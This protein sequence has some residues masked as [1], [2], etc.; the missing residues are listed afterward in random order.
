MREQSKR[1]TFA[2]HLV[3]VGLIGT[4]MIVPLPF[5]ADRPWAWSMLA[6][7]VGALFLV[8]GVIAALSRTH[9]TAS[10]RP[11]F[12]ALAL[13][14]LVLI[15]IF[16]Q[17]WD[18][19]PAAWHNSLWRLAGEA[20]G[21][22]VASSISVDAEQ[23]RTGLMRLLT[24][25]GVFMLSFQLCGTAGRAERMVRWV[26]GATL[27]YALYGIIVQLAGIERVLWYPK[28]GVG[29]YGVLSSTF[30]S[31]NNFATYAGLG[32]ICAVTLLFKPAMRK[33]DMDVSWRF[34]TQAVFEYLF[35]RTWIMMVAASILFASI[36]MT[37]SRAGVAV[38]ILGVAAYLGLIALTRKRRR[39]IYAGGA[40]IIIGASAIFG[41]GGDGTLDRLT[42]LSDAAQERYTVYERTIEGIKD[43]P[44][45]GIGSGSFAEI[46]PM[47][48]SES[49]TAAFQ[50]AHN[51]YLENALEL[52]VP[53]TVMLMLALAWIMVICFAALRHYGRRANIPCMGLAITALVATHSLVDYTMTV[54]AIAVTYAALLGV[55][56]SQA[57]RLARP[58]P[59]AEERRQF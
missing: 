21:I 2:E 7:I 23:S 40:A 35:A 16:I 4:L 53:A 28:K 13:F 27:I 52:G 8:W 12:P 51:T 26:L 19:T 55:A 30:L 1:V 49:L 31:R 14:T 29:D 11:I 17:S 42:F 15:W 22:N 46:F 41:I 44:L 57:L 48:R 37:E 10:L 18:G 54:P 34:A 32:L 58:E 56:C 39:F 36:L 6:V 45:V 50:R 33:G 3:F 5:G 24:Y 20:L 25:G 38:V 43:V 59:V 9:Q 47:Y